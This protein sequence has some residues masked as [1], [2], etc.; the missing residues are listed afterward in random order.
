[1]SAVPLSTCLLRMA[2]DLHSVLNA[3]DSEYPPISAAHHQGAAVAT[4]ASRTDGFY[5]TVVKVHEPNLPP[6]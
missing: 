6:R 5:S 4:S 1:M 2:C 3:D